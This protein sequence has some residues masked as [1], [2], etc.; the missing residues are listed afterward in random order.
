MEIGAISLI[1]EV[2]ASQI[3]VL[4]AYLNGNPDRPV[5]FN[6]NSNEL[7]VSWYALT[8]IY[9]QKGE[10]VV[11]LQLKAIGSINEAVYVSLAPEPTNELADGQYNVISNAPLSLHV[12]E[13]SL[14]TGIDET[15]LSSVELISY[16]N[17]FRSEKTFA[18]NIPEHAQVIL[19]THNLMGA[20]IEVL[21]DEKMEAGDHE[22]T[23]DL[24]SY[25]AGIYT[26]TLK[27]IT[28]NDEVVRTI[29]IVRIQ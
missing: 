7:R 20:R 8:P 2:P 18:F 13:G 19:E 21:M 6:V 17:P 28:A 25:K 15:E 16:P 22:L 29:R 9:V 23:V 14:T 5:Q 10:P 1:M 26:A 27:V 12:I 11:T 4:G 3:E 24:N